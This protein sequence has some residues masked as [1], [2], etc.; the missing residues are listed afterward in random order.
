M[1]IIV[2]RSDSVS[3]KP[4]TTITTTP[5]H[6]ERLLAALGE[7][8]LQQLAVQLLKRARKGRRILET[9]DYD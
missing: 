8:R 7:Q 6:L 2:R 3:K 5:S 4:A 9:G 1:G